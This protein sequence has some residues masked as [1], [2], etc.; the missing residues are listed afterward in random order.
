MNFSGNYLF[1]QWFN[2]LAD[3][4][5]IFQESFDKT[6][7][8]SAPAWLHD[9]IV[10]S[11]E[12][13]QDHEKKLFD[14]LRYLEKAGYRASKRKSDFFMSQTKWLGHEIEKRNETDEEK[15]EAILKLNTTKNSKEL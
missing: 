11:R 6:L 7:R 12:S 5:T 13:M 8:Y 3:I 10:V 15:V 2:G 4:P 1:K 14:F 9:K